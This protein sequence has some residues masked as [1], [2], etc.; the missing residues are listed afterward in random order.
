MKKIFIGTV[1][2]IALFTGAFLLFINPPRTDYYTQIDNL[3]YKA[4]NSSGGVVDFTGG[5]KYLYTLR[6]YT[7]DGKEKEITFGA[8]NV[9]RENAYIKLEYTLTRG[10]LSWSEVKWEELPASVQGVLRQS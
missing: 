1:I 9:L 2:V 8:D 5:M 10:V 3:K 6:S 4:N 7:S